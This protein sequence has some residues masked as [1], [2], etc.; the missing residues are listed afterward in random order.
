MAIK[1]VTVSQ[2]SGY[3]KRVLQS[4]P[5]L[6]N[7]SVI[8]E[9]SNLKFHGSGHIY[10]TLKDENSKINCFL[11]SDKLKNIR[12]E[13]A[14]GMK[15]IA[16]GYIHLYEKGGSYSLNIRDIEVFGQGSL[17]MAFQK[18]KE[19]L[20]K[21]GLFDTKHKKPLPKFPR[22]IAIVT[23]ET[24]AAI[25]DMLKIIKSRNNIVDIIIFPV[26]VQGACAAE[27][28]SEAI[29]KINTLYPETD[30]IITG[31][32]GGSL[33]ELWAFNEEIV[34]RS[35]FNSVIPVISAVG[36]EIDVTISDFV[37]DRRA[38]T[39]TAAAQMSVPDIGELKAYIK[40]LKE[41]LVSS[42]IHGIQN[43]ERLLE[44]YNIETLTNS[45]KNRIDL[46]ASQA[47]AL[48]IKLDALNPGNIMALGYG[49]ILNRDGK[50]VGSAFAF[51]PGDELTV[52][53]AD[54]NALCS[55]NEITGV[56]G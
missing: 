12:Y 18:L 40:S 22:K 29:G 7:V 44:A 36:H 23:S 45:F 34:A 53:F 21:E 25:E 26:L 11:P 2:L 42:I 1:P 31:R 43:K 24:G 30:I 39:P 5:L 16:A 52:V 17:S 33:E 32:G 6:G 49:A 14:D 3:I 19:K 38:E 27:E 47:N 4:D 41:T 8:G 51:S 56:K 15:I 10:F 20:E 48:K 35:I 46:F 54:G 50:L 9:T 55:V 37:A 28:I 13:L